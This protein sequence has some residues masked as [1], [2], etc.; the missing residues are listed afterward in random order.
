MGCHKIE[1][2]DWNRY[3]LLKKEIAEKVNSYKEHPAIDSKH[4]IAL[5][6]EGVGYKK[7]MQIMNCSRATIWYYCHN[8]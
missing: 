8:L 1:H 5:Y 6:K 7:I 2:F 4:I 3:N